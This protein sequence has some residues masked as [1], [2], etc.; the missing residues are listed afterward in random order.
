ML[1]QFTGLGLWPLG[2]PSVTGFASA[3]ALAPVAA[4]PPVAVVA[5]SALASPIRQSSAATASPVVVTPLASSV[6]ASAAARGPHAALGPTVTLHSTWPPSM[7]LSLHP[8]SP[9]STGFCA[10][11]DCVS[12]S[13]SSLRRPPSPPPRRRQ[14]LRRVPHVRILRF[15]AHRSRSGLLSYCLSSSLP[16]RTPPPPS[17]PQSAGLGGHPN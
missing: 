4:A 15:R 1:P 2:A 5:A 9:R 10:I 16:R 17:A 11:W 14:S 3:A 6:P 12:S 8:T 7:L 13:S